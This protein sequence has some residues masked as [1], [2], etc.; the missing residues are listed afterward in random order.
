MKAIKAL[1]VLFAAVILLNVQA[2]S[3]EAHSHHNFNENSNFTFEAEDFSFD[4]HE[5]FKQL[6]RLVEWECNRCGKTMRLGENVNPYQQYAYSCPG[7]SYESER[8]KSMFGSRHMWH[9]INV[10]DG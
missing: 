5:H 4:S 1:L 8:Q 7:S 6:A 10:I 9:I 3:T 2:M